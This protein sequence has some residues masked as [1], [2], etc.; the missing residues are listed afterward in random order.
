MHRLMRSSSNAEAVRLADS[1]F[2]RGK[3]RLNASSTDKKYINLL[4][5][6]ERT[7]PTLGNLINALHA[8]GFTEAGRLRVVPGPLFRS[9]HGAS[10]HTNMP[11]SISATYQPLHDLFDAA[12]AMANAVRPDPELDLRGLPKPL[13]GHHS[14]RRGADTVARQT[15]HLTGA[16]ERDIDLVFGWKEAFYSKE[17]QLHYESSFDRER[18][19]SGGARSLP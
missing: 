13:W 6:D 2:L 19:G 10:G 15:M 9:T 11:L 7:S 4:S 17:M 12:H 1:V 3:Q 8:A 14:D 16:T 5:A 18:Q